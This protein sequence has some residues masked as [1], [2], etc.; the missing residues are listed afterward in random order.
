MSQSRFH[1]CRVYDWQAESRPAKV[2]LVDRLWPRGISKE[3]LTGV[4]WLR[5]VSPSDELR[6]EFNHEPD[7]WPEFVQRYHAQLDQHPESWA[8]LMAAAE[9]GEVTLLYAAKNEELN[10]AVA[11]RLYLE[12]QLSR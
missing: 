6:R 1:I 11:L 12:D 9:A 10:N 2:F 3:Q 7:R 5:E 4:R 8:P